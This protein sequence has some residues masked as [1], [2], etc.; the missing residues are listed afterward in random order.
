MISDYRYAALWC[1][2]TTGFFNDFSQEL[3]D[4]GVAVG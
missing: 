1:Q 4:S 2:C 3:V